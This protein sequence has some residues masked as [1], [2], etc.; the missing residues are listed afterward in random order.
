MSE[1]EVLYALAASSCKKLRLR[2][3]N[4]RI[5]L[6]QPSLSRLVERME[7]DGL[8]RREA[9]PTDLRGT[10][11]ALTDDG[12]AVQR[13]V[14]SAHE[15]KIEQYVGGALTQRELLTLTRL[16]DKLRL[17]QERIPS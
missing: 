15:D 17:A 13:K 4:E 2:S 8:V 11:V 10:V 12:D 3:L 9:D 6:T 1:F 5:L 14:G 7:R 16:C